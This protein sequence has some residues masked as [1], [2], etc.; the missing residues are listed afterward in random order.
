VATNEYKNENVEKEKLWK[1]G[2]EKANYE[3]KLLPKLVK[4]IKIKGLTTPVLS[5]CCQFYNVYAYF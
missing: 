3:A 5:R 4:K 1:N 2:E